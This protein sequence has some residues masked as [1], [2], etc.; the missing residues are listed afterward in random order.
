MP[1]ALDEAPLSGTILGEA[2]GRSPLLDLIV[3]SAF[4]ALALM[5]LATF[6]SILDRCLSDDRVGRTTLA[7]DSRPRR[8]MSGVARVSRAVR[9]RGRHREFE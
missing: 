6:K 8:N 9:R 4:L 3:W 2:L 5:V 1:P 7:G